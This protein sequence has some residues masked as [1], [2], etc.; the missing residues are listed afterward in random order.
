ML[1]FDD[2]VKENIKKRNINCS[3]IRDYQCRI[4]IIGGS[5]H[6]KQNHY[7]I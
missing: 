3:Q 4:L 5:D 2:V 6:E 1:N 7:L